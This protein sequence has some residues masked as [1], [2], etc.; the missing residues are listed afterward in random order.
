[1]VA[2]ST[3]EVEGSDGEGVDVAVA[4]AA[5]GVSASCGSAAG[6]GGDDGVST[7]EAVVGSRA[8]STRASIGLAAEPSVPFA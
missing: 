7:V 3:D 8:R 2:R 5:G 6:L 1:L 4:L